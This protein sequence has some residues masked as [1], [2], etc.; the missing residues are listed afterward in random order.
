MSGVRAKPSR[1]NHPSAG[2]PAPPRRGRAFAF[3]QRL[4]LGSHAGEFLGALG[5]RGGHLAAF[6]HVFG[7]SENLR[8]DPVRF[9]IENARPI[10]Q[11]LSQLAMHF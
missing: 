4:A 3:Q 6:G 2:S 10:A 7:V 11:P 8:D 5:Q 9:A 1:E